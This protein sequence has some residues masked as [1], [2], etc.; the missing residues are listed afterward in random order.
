MVGMFENFFNQGRA[1]ERG[2]IIRKMLNANALTVEQIAD[3]L[4]LPVDEV[5]QIAQ[6][7]PAEA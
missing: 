2:E 6:K 5:K 1:E 3:I 7:V 4:K